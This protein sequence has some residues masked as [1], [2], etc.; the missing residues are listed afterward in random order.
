M[1]VHSL[2]TVAVHTPIVT[3][4]L[5]HVKELLEAERAEL[6]ALQLLTHVR[7]DIKFDPRRLAPHAALLKRETE[8]RFKVR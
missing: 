7:I 4:A 1:N 2:V 6:D 3:R 5:G 8:R